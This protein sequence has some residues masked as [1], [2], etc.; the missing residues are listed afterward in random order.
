MYIKE[1]LNIIIWFLLNFIN[2]IKLSTNKLATIIL[3]L[4]YFVAYITSLFVGPSFWIV[5]LIIFLFLCWNLKYESKQE[6]NRTVLLGC[7]LSIF[8]YFIFKSILM[9]IT[10]N[11]FSILW[12]ILNSIIA[13]MP[14]FI[15]FAINIKRI[16]NNKVNYH[17]YEDILTIEEYKKIQKYLGM[18][19]QNINEEKET[20]NIKNKP[21]HNYKVIPS[22]NFKIT[23]KEKKKIIKQIIKKKYKIW[24]NLKYV[25][26][27]ISLLLFVL[28]FY[29]MFRL[30]YPTIFICCVMVGSITFV[31]FFVVL[32]LLYNLGGIGINDK[33]NEHIWI[34]N[35]ILHHFWQH[36]FAA[37]L[38]SWSTDSTAIEFQ[39]YIDSI[40]ELKYD[41][42]TKKIEFYVSGNQILYD[43][44]RIKSIKETVPISNAKYKH[45]MYDYL[46]PNL[47]ET[48][49]SIGI[50]I[51]ETILDK[52]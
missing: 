18:T 30:Y 28:G 7:Y 9:L 42:K 41:P 39:L 47:I 23:Q 49:K 37:G 12:M 8:L 10:R 24:N 11:D 45:T 2:K 31:S 22:L 27:I 13:L 19:T 17:N 15:I 38:N 48:F 14:I 44:F 21:F 25:C 35:G 4:L 50:T 33:L 1:T 43:D 16:K 20:K 32:A 51:E 6:L 52:K 36:S 5:F 26:I 34:E 46:N 3:I 40:N 29:F